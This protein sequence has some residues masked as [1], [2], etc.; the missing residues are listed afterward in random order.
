MNPIH[1]NGLSSRVSLPLIGLLGAFDANLALYS[2]GMF[3][4]PGT[5]R[6]FAINSLLGIV[7]VLTTYTFCLSLLIPGGIAIAFARVFPALRSTR[8]VLITQAVLAIVIVTQIAMEP[9]PGNPAALPRDRTG[10]PLVTV[11]VS[12]GMPFK[13]AITDPRGTCYDLPP[14]VIIGPATQSAPF[15]CSSIHLALYRVGLS[16]KLFCLPQYD[17]ATATAGGW[18]GSTGTALSFSNSDDRDVH[19]VVFR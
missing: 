2:Y 12:N 14:D 8:F 18:C 15:H 4:T 1:P 17:T 9:S 5:T 19:V 10:R 7:L 16:R 6:D 3:G 13:V 11:N